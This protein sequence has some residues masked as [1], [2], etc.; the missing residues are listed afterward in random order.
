L[1]RSAGSARAARVAGGVASFVATVGACDAIGPALF[2]D[3]EPAWAPVRLLLVLAV[4]A[5]GAGAGAAAA[6]IVLAAGRS[7][8]LQGEPEPVPLSGAALVAVAALALVLGAAVRF[9]GLERLPFPLWHDEILLVPDALALQ[10]RPADLRDS[11]RTVRDDGGSPSGTVGVL[12]LEAFR[13]S[14]STFGT[15]VF[16]VRFLSAAG[17]VLSLLTAMLLARALL[18]KGGATLAGLTLA[19]LRWS[20]IVSRWCWNMILLA[21]LVDVATL[22]AIRARRNGSV[23]AAL[24]AGLIAGLAT[25]VYLSAWIAA[26]ALAGFLLWPGGAGGRRFLLAGVFAAALLAAALPLW[27]LREG[28]RAPYLVR[29][30]RHNVLVEMRHAKSPMPLLRAARKGLLAPWLADPNPGNDL[31]GRTRLPVLPAVAFAVSLLAAILRP[32]Q[33]LHALMLSHA[34]AALL[35]SLAWGERLSPNGSRFAYLTTVTAVAVASGL[36]R[37]IGAAPRRLRRAAALATVGGL[38]ASGAASAGELL[39]WD[40]EQGMYVAVVGQHTSVAWAALRWEPYGEVRVEQSPLYAPLT[41]DVIRRYRILPRREAAQAAPAGAR[42]RRFRIAP[43]GTPPQ[44]GERVVERV[45]DA[46]GKDWA[47]VLGRRKG[48]ELR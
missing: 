44:A 45:R 41:I 42:A 24:A 7:G 9:A 12:Y 19:G 16:G 47:V 40:R 4:G 8:A 6:G 18:P 35:A 39:R 21:P 29:A 26:A 34:G 27:L 11:V 43:P 23:A 20:L 48:G 46:W 1:T 36:L 15:N 38:F 37:L 31:P 22:A 28:R 33:D 10:G 32:R 17:G 2:L 25:H 14:L 5:A 3:P 13:A 30:N